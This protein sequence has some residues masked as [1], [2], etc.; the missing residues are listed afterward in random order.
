MAQGLEKERRKD[1]MI[2]KFGHGS[3]SFDQER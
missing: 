1:L 3:E 2:N